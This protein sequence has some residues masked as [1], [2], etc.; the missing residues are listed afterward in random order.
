MSQRQ[1]INENPMRT[2]E[3][4]EFIFT[5]T[6][7][8]TFTFALMAITMANPLVNARTGQLAA[9]ASQVGRRIARGGRLAAGGP[10][11]DRPYP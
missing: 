3:F 6:F 5:F 11:V 8:S 10:Q 2:Y 9:G 7:T 4:L 1:S